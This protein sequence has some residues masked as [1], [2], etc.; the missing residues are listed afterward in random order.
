M[1]ARALIA[2]LAVVLVCFAPHAVARAQTPSPSP[3]ATPSASPSESP[4]AEPAQPEKP[5][6]W[7]VV[8]RVR[9][10]ISNWFSDL[11][12]SAVRPV[13][14]LV[15]RT[16]F[17]T[18]MLPA[19][20]RVG[21]L[22]RFSLGIADATLLLFVL[23]GAGIVISGGGG[24]S[25]QLTAKEL[26]PRLLLATGA[27]NVSM[28]ALSQM[29]TFSNALS[30][31]MLGAA[32]DPADASSR[33]SAS[34]GAAALANPFMALFAL[35]IVVLGIL[36]VISY[37]VRIAA[38]VLL[39]TGAP[40]MLAGHALPQ[41]EGMARTWWR[42]TAAFLVAPVI[43]SMLLAAAF[44]IFLTGGGVLGLPVGSGLIDL[45]VIGCLLYMLYKIPFWALN[46][47][48][49]GGGN[50]AWAQAKRT[51]KAAATAATKAVAA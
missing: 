42:A 46:I 31:A 2:V 17:A 43:Q 38:L 23:A 40:L 16:V 28:L 30:R 33:M 34:I 26:L 37:V 39:A 49:S 25:S 13:F 44:R 7:D 18:P 41:S 20:P 29:I 48:L 5:P 6:F 50:R 9:Y 4:S 36:V 14:D 19:N 35:A 3:T 11:V 8:G 22:W 21:E 32:F 1:K 47:A 27:A 24:F 10:A 15:G 51:G 45:L 12:T